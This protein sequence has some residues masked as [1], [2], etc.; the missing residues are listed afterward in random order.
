MLRGYQPGGTA[1]MQARSRQEHGVMEFGVPRSQG[2]MQKR[3]QN[4]C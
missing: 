1:G 2:E 3:S 4:T